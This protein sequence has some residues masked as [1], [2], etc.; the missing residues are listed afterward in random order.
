MLK[1]ILEPEVM[2]TWEDAV[3]YD[4]MDHEEVNTAFARRALE[5]GPPSGLVL[6]GGTGTARIPIL[7]VQ[8]NPN[9][10][11]IGIDLSNNMLKV[12]ETNINDVG[13]AGSISL[14]LVDA[15]DLPYPDNHFD[16]VISNSLIHHVPDPMP[17]LRE[18]NRVVK[19]NAA[20][21][22]RDL[23][24]PE[25][26]KAVDMLVKK[27]AA[28]CTHRQRKLFQ[29]S[30][31]AAFTIEEVEG[32]LLESGIRGAQVVQSSDRHW[33]IE[34]KW[35]KELKKDFPLFPKGSVPTKGE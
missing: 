6:D 16:M 21:L 33:S 35:Y 19:A 29:D 1:R 3:E 24:R 9:L 14:H 18:I 15:K 2:D 32:M 5:L 8:E 23:I 10:Q 13:L 7:M 25:H 26:Q 11:I 20:I 34:R 30:L 27:Y 17:F 28:D 31:M 12:G 4:A 22:I